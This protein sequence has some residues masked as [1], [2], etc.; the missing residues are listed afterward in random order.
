V[1]VCLHDPCLPIDLTVTS[2][3]HDLHRVCMG[4]TTLAAALRAEQV[5]LAGTTRMVRDFRRWMRWS[6]FAPASRAAA[7]R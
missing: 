6:S 5:R 7:T 1:S 2:T 4:R 3:V